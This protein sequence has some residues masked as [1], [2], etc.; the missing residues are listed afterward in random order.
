MGCVAVINCSQQGSVL[1]DAKGNSIQ[2]SSLKGKWVIINYWA[3]WCESCVK[4]I[5]ELNHFYQHNQDKNIVLYGVNYDHM[6]MSDLELAM[7]KTQIAFPVILD[8][9][10]QTW[11]LDSIDAL[12][13]TFIIDPKGHVVKKILGGNTEKSLFATVH[14]LQKASQV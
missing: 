7:H 5:P 2:V 12:P 3:A 11:K 1:H 8:D 4:E 13:V 14:A 6:P 9:P 10:A